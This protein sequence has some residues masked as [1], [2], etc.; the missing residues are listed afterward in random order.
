MVLSGLAIMKDYVER[1][2]KA[3]PKEMGRLGAA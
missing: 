1:L 2:M 3:R